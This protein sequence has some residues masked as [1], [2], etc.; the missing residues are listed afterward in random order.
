MA[1]DGPSLL[2]QD[3][4]QHIKLNWHEIKAVATHA[5]VPLTNMVTFSQTNLEAHCATLY[6]KQQEKLKFFKA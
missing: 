4:L 1:G 6:V 2:G 3:L 5:G